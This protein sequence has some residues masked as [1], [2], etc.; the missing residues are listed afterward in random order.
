LRNEGFRS[1]ARVTFYRHHA[2]HAWL[3]GYYSGLPERMVVT[4]DGYGDLDQVHTSNVY[5]NG[6]LETMAVSLGYGQSAGMF[7]KA[8]TELLGFRPMRHEGKVLG[9]AAFG[10]PAPLLGAFRKALRASEDGRTFVSDFGASKAADAALHGYLASVIMGHPR[11]NVAAAA[12]QTL[13]DAFLTV[14]RT[15]AKDTGL[16]KIAL[17]GGVAENVKLNQ[18][19][20]ALPEIDEVFVFPGMSDTG[21]SVGTAILAIEETAPGFLARTQH[22]LR[23]VYLGPEYTDFQVEEAL[24]GSGL[25]YEKLDQTTLV[26]RTARAINEGWIVG[27]FHGR[28]EFGPRALGS[29]SM[30]GRPTDAGIN[31]SLNARLERTEFMPFAPSALY[32]YADD[33]FVGAGKAKQAAEFMTITFDVR[34]KWHDRIPAVVH[35]D[36]TARPQLVRKDRNRLYYQVIDRYRELSGIPL[37]LNTS[38]NV[39]EEPIV[40]A[41]PEAIRAVAEDRID[42]LA[43]GSFWV[44]N[45]KRGPFR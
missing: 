2:V 27:W 25:V 37:V 44:D 6:A 24:R 31:K 1:D 20:A 38:F 11:E 4:A 18:R 32:E 3:A 33:L 30:I 29:R 19:I 45:P 41:P 9:L 16:R 23:D 42:A 14:V 21:N 39:R 5:R 13:E 10:D 43:I 34:E 8:I 12:Q 7:Y 22:P 17:N 36:G 26:D 15:L 28:M 35:V 40:C